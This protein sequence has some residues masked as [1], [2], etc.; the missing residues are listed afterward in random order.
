MGRF[1]AQLGPRDIARR[2]VGITKFV[3]NPRIASERFRH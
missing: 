1:L 3:R 2:V